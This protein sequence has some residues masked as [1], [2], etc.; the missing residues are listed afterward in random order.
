MKKNISYYLNQDYTIR[1]KENADGSYYAEVKELTGCMT[2]GDTKEEAL[3][4]IKDAKKAWLET[5]LKRGLIIPELRHK[6]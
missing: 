4:M 2:E 6:N 5:S 3:A 1:L